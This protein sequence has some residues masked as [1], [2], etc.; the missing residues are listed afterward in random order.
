M[1]I[2]NGLALSIPLFL[3]TLAATANAA[4]R[5]YL[6]PQEVQVV[7]DRLYFTAWVEA[8]QDGVAPELALRGASAPS[9]VVAI[10]APPTSSGF[11]N[12]RDVGRYACGGLA[13]SNRADSTSFDACSLATLVR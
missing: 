11:R 8:G 3:T 6:P 5:A 10:P 2:T 12:P 1:R 9:A 7:N 13:L 4:P